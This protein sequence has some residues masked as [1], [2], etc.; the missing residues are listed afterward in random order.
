MSSVEIEYVVQ[1]NMSITLNLSPSGSLTKEAVFDE[2]THRLMNG[3]YD[4]ETFVDGI[5]LIEVACG[6]QRHSIEL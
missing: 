6:G 5:A 3:D 1:V 4:L 2:L